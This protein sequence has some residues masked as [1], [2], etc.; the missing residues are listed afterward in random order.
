MDTT[1]CCNQVLERR[2]WQEIDKE[3]L[4]EDG[5]G[6]NIFSPFDPYKA[7]TGRSST[8]SKTTLF[9]AFLFGTVAGYMMDFHLSKHDS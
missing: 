5:N 6:W 1:R 8:P 3:R 4:W 9:V 7:E 2:Q